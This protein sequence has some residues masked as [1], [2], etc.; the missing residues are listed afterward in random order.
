MSGPVQSRFVD[1]WRET[2][3]R[4]KPIAEDVNISPFN[5]S[6]SA[7]SYSG[8]LSW[9]NRYPVDDF[10][11]YSELFASIHSSRSRIIGSTAR[12]V[13]ISPD[14]VSQFRVVKQLVTS[15]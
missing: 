6:M 3:S 13:L 1:L 14:G 8:Q 5:G 15:E 11:S 4:G 10:F 2:I 7:L 9:R 12:H